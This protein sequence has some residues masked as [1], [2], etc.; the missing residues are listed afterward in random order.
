MGT[1]IAQPPIVT[2]GGGRDLYGG[3]RIRLADGQSLTLLNLRATGGNG[4]LFYNATLDRVPEG[5]NLRRVPAPLTAKVVNLAAYPL[6]R[7]QDEYTKN[8]FLRTRGR[9][10][11]ANSD[12]I[13]CDSIASCAVGFV[14]VT[15]A[16]GGLGIDA[17][18]IVYDNVQ[19]KDLFDFVD[20]FRS[21]VQ[22]NPDLR[23]TNSLLYVE[24]VASAAMQLCAAV[25][26]FNTFGLFHRDLKPENVVVEYR[27]PAAQQQLVPS[28]FRLLLIDFATLCYDTPPVPLVPT[29]DDP[30]PAVPDGVY[31]MPDELGFFRYGS[32]EGFVDPDAYA[33]YQPF[34][35]AGQFVVTRATLA[36]RFAHY[37][38]YAVGATIHD[39]LEPANFVTPQDREVLRTLTRIVAEMLGPI[40]RRR[41]LGAY[42]LLFE[43]V[44]RQA[45]HGHDQVIAQQ[46]Q[47][48]SGDDDGE[49]SGEGEAGVNSNRMETA[50]A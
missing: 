40:E 47:Q 5:A 13:I 28:K 21:R 23:D 8:L 4:R 27:P 30:R 6:E 48:S 25:H 7:L 2:L 24:F 19:G 37:E 43:H 49:A 31:C 16:T 34:F 17:G 1:R 39:L 26:L 3:R 22:L 33:I 14:V 10:F 50:E 20:G 18:I 44:L 12:N 36:Q 29:A 15:A 32:T 35:V 38:T 11:D 42:S 45:K 9:Q 46:Q 41:S